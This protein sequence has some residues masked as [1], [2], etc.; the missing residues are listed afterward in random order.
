L[1]VKLSLQEKLRDLR[2]EK[3]LRL[4]DVSKETGIPTST[5]QR[6]ESDKDI[7]V[8]YQDI[9]VLTRFYGVSADYLFG[10]TD[11]RQHLNTD[12]N[13]LSLS[14]EAISCLISGKLNNRLLSEIIAHPE[15][16]DFL[17]AFEV[18]IDRKLSENMNIINMSYQAA[19]DAINKQNVTLSRDEYLITL[20]E[21]NIDPDDYL[22]FRLTKRFDKIIQSIYNTHEKEALAETGGGYLKTINDQLKKYQNAK[23]ETNNEKHAK[24]ALLADQLGVDLGKAPEEEKQFLLSL[25]GRSK[26]NRLLNDENKQRGRQAD[27]RTYTFSKYMTHSDTFRLRRQRCLVGSCGG[28]SPPIAAI[29]PN[30]KSSRDPY[31]LSVRP[32]TCFA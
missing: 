1:K 2:E 22:C 24:L 7:H 6:F 21:A 26:F 4:S 16:V 8:G 17:A 20:K 28:P 15:F 10:L 3:K 25:L 5:L 31:R 30:G 11:N 32:F 18:L 9:E 19:V 27:K 14:D 12:I 13:K 23:H 29:R